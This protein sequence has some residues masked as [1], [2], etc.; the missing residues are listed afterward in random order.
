MNNE[1]E[2][3]MGTL[4]D[5]NKSIMIQ[6]YSGMDRETLR[7]KL[8][9][10]KKYFKE[11]EKYHMLLCN[12]RRD[13]TVFVVD[14]YKESSLKEAVEAMK[15]CMINRGTILD[16]EKQP[17]GAYEIWLK[18]DEEAFCYYLFPYDQAIIVC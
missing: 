12:E 10:L 4:Y 7:T 18:I 8:K 6:N 11:N 2:V 17:D 13:Y 3:G 9:D 16:I 1:V 15:D 5:V 14:K